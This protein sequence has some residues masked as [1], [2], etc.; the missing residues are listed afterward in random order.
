MV[1]Q[2]HQREGSQVSVDGEVV[3][4]W[5]KALR[6]CPRCDQR[7][8]PG[9]FYIRQ[10]RPGRDRPHCRECHKGLVLAWQRHNRDRKNENNRRYR[11]RR[12]AERQAQQAGA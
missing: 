2:G 7:K 9:E 1:A 6:L 10:D 4:R 12:K 3:T 11:A 8:P 5:V